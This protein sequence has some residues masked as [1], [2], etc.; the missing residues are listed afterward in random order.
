LK[1]GTAAHWLARLER[2]CF[3]QLAAKVRAGTLSA[4]A[5]ALEAG[6]RKKPTPFEQW[7]ASAFA[8]PPGSC[9]PTP[10]PQ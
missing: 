9:A 5:A 1:Y 7:C 4:N 2:D 6:F 8:A 3:D 10:L